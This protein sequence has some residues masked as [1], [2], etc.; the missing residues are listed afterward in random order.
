MHQHYLFFVRSLTVVL[1]LWWGLSASVCQALPYLSV[2][3]D[4]SPLSGGVF[5]LAFDFF[6]GDATANNT[7]TIGGFGFGVGGSPSGSP[8]LIGGATGDVFSTVTLSDSSG[9][10]SSFVQEFTPGNLLSF[11]VDVTT[12]FAGG[13]PDS[14]VFSLLDSNGIPLPT[15]DPLGTDAL[16]SIE[17]G[18][19]GPVVRT[20]GSPTLDG[21][22]PPAAAVPEPG[23]LVL[24]GSGLAGLAAARRRRKKPGRLG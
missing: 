9:F 7:V 21:A 15:M 22:A 8:I 4:T 1:G 17:L 10:F 14:F 11:G 20:F 23:T 2:S 5:S 18:S 13:T 12:N 24:L 19:S 6:D 16:L 3:F